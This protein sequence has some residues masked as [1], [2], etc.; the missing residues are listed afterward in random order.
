M[1]VWVALASNFP[2]TIEVIIITLGMVT[3]SDMVMH[4]A[5]MI[6]TLT[7]VQGHTDLNHENKK[8]SVISET[9]QT[10]PHQVCW[11]DSLTKGLYNLFSVQWPCSSFKVT[12][13]SQTWQVLNLY[14]NSRIL[15][16]YLSYCIQTWHD[17]KLTH[18]IYA[19]ARAGDLDARSH[20]VG[21]GKKIS[22]ELSRQLSKQ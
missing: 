7:F 9:I 17:S 14:Y 21:K 20:W 3:A 15:G 13:A 2:E 22:I 1:Y 6:L 10:I 16:Q 12:S 18:G 19:H 5:L 4:H 11:E 8:C